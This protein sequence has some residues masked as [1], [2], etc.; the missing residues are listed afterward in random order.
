MSWSHYFKLKLE[1]GMG[2]AKPTNKS[3]YGDYELDI[4]NATSIIPKV[5]KNLQTVKPTWKQM[6]LRNKLLSREMFAKDV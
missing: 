5:D 4:K 1:E 6:V 3:K 2:G